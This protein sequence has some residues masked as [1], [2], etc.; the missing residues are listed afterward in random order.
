[1]TF[2][3]L[4]SAC[5][6]SYFRKFNSDTNCLAPE[7]SWNF[8]TTWTLSCFHHVYKT[9][10]T[11]M[12]LFQLC[13]QPQMQSEP[14]VQTSLC[15]PWRDTSLA[16][17]FWRNTFSFSQ[18]ETFG[19]WGQSILPV[20]IGLLFNDAN[21]VNNYDCFLSTCLVCNFKLSPFLNNL[22]FFIPLAALSR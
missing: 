16:L 7:V 15:W 8:H 19:G 20:Y 18:N 3:A 12:T 5:S 1:M 11:R 17:P 13:C 21:F 10:P 4:C 9:K 22:Q 6:Y 2:P 14:L